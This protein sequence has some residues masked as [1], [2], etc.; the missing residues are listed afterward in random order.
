M[1]AVVFFLYEYY[2][3][4]NKINKLKILQNKELVQLLHSA[5]YNLKTFISDMTEIPTDL[6]HII[7]SPVGKNQ[8]FS[9]GIQRTICKVIF[10]LCSDTAQI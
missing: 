1:P 8:Y 4:N 7:V 9:A 6:R 2:L 10:Q 5:F 3:K